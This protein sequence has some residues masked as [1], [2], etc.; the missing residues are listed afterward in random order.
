[1]VAHHVGMSGQHRNSLVGSAINGIQARHCAIN[2]RVFFFFFE[3]KKK[4]KKNCPWPD[5]R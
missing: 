1:M 4:K 2:V 5:R 3:K